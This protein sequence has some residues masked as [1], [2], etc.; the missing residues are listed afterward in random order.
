[1]H[2]SSESW[3]GLFGVVVWN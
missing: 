1:M 3:I 2:S